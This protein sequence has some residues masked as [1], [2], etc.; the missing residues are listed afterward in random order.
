MD[1]AVNGVTVSL[2]TNFLALSKMIC[3]DI[4]FITLILIKLLVT[5]KSGKRFLTL[6]FYIPLRH[7]SVFDIV[8][9]YI[10]LFLAILPFAFTLL[11]VF[12]N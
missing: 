3:G 2:K 5:M 12:N 7:L 11:V 4:L 10:M 8:T 6:C 1:T 9:G